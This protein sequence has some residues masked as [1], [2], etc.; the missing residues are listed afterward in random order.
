LGPIRDNE[1]QLVATFRSR[2]SLL[3]S[4]QA[5][6]FV[7]TK[8]WPN[9]DA[10]PYLLNN[11]RS[12]GFCVVPTYF[13]D[14]AGAATANVPAS[15][16]AGF[17]FD[18]DNSAPDDFLTK[19]STDFYAAGVTRPWPLEE[20]NSQFPGVPSV[21]YSPTTS[22][23][24]LSHV[25]KITGET[26]RLVGLRSTLT[27]T[28]A[29]LTATGSVIAGDGEA[30]HVPDMGLVNKIEDTALNSE[31]PVTPTAATYYDG[32]YTIPLST[33]NKNP[34]MVSLG[35]ATPGSIMECSW[36]PTNDDALQ[37][38]DVMPTIVSPGALNNLNIL[39]PQSYP[40]PNMASLVGNWGANIWILRDVPAGSTFVLEVTASYQIGVR[41]AGS[42]IGF[43]MNQA[44]LAR[45]YIVDWRAFASIPCASR[46]GGT[47]RKWM[48]TNKGRIGH[49]I[50][51]GQLPAA[52]GAVPMMQGLGAVSP[53]SDAAIT[54]TI[55]INPQK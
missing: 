50:L 32:I 17:S 31:V 44:R 6:N 20:F 18:P 40:Y 19:A 36:L 48:Q 39:T 16:V 10:D 1:P 35:M 55:T 4:L 49:M 53:F 51:F 54:S 23:P 52:P 8:S 7:E 45:S 30:Y 33:G 26:H 43:L 11:K 38:D 14:S 3:L 25:D 28:T 2:T 5:P 12:I 34:R 46:L 9:T 13:I 15:M 42:P 29:P 47:Y 41:V 21:I 24:A 22:N 27:C 37:F